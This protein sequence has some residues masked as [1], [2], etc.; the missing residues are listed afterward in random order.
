MDH[1]IEAVGAAVVLLKECYLDS[2]LMT[3]AKQIF[4]Q[5][6]LLSDTVSET[7]T[8]ETYTFPFSNS[9]QFMC[10]VLFTVRIVCRRFTESGS[11]TP[12]KHLRTKKQKKTK[13]DSPADGQLGRGGEE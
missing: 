9:V 6:T 13:Q 2:S 5:P 8:L 11:L 1:I 4:Q 7:S 12:R 10:K 3:N